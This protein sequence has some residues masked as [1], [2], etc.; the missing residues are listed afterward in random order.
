MSRYLLIESRDPFDSRDCDWLYETAK[1]LS[2]VGN[3]VTVFFVQNGVLPSRKGSR[4]ENYLHQLSLYNVK[5]L[6]D[7]LSL[8]E[9]AI[10][11][12]HLVAEVSIS[13][14]DQ[15]VDLLMDDQLKPI[16]H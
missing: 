10:S 1:G 14:M 6:A 11:D 13:N 3:E 4:Y 9:R 12:R 8:S 16:W 2:K 5:L 7:S 15:L